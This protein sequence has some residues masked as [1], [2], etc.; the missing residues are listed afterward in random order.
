MITQFYVKCMLATHWYKT[1]ALKLL[2]CGN[3][4][5]KTVKRFLSAFP[6]NCLHHWISNRSFCKCMMSQSLTFNPKPFFAL[7]VSPF[8]L[9]AAPPHNDCCLLTLR[10]RHGELA[11]EAKLLN[12]HNRNSWTS[13]APVPVLLCSSL[14]FQ[15]SPCWCCSSTRVCVCVRMLGRPRCICRIICAAFLSACRAAARSVLFTGLCEWRAGKK[16]LWGIKEINKAVFSPLGFQINLS[17]APPSKTQLLV[18]FHLTVAA[19]N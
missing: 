17:G 12:R 16:V 11:W 13:P 8:A 5:Q 18:C 3:C 15:L 2:V 6:A 1:R 7:T 14:L 4:L 19:F 10:W 9:N